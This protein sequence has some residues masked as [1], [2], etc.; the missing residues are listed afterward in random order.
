MHTPAARGMLEFLHTDLRPDNIM[1]MQCAQSEGP[2]LHGEVDQLWFDPSNI[3]KVPGS[4]IGLPKCKAIDMW[5]LGCVRV[6][7]EEATSVEL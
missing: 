4:T 6:K 5:G 2:A 1:L 7:D 3:Q